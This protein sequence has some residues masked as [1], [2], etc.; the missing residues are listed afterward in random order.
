MQQ[1]EVLEK[2]TPAQTPT[3]FRVLAV[4]AL[5]AIVAIAV[6]AILMARHWPF[7][8][9][10]VVQCLQQESGNTVR[11]ANYRETYFPHPG[12]VA[13][14]VT[15]LDPESGNAPPAITIQ[16]LTIEGN[17]LGLLSQHLSTIRA[18]GLRVQVPP[19]EKRSS[20]SNFFTT[21]SN[22]SIGVLV[23]DGA[24]ISFEPSNASEQPLVFR[25]PR[26][27][28]RSIGKNHP[29]SFA[30]TVLIPLPPANVEISGQ[31]GPWKLGNAGETPISASYTLHDA[32]LS[33][34]GGIQGKVSAKG[35]L[36]GVLQRINT[37]GDTDAP[38]FMVTESHHK[39]HL[40]THYQALVNGLNGDVELQPVIANFGKTTLVAQGKIEGESKATGAGKTVAMSVYS[41]RARI[42]DLLR[43]FGSSDPPPM[44]GPVQFRAQVN[45]P[46]EDRPFLKKVRLQGDFGI[47]GAQY[48]SRETQKDV[49]VASARAMGEA[50]KV[51]DRNDK[52]H[53]DSYDPGKVLS[54]VKGHVVM[55]NAVATLTDLSFDVPGASALLNGNYDLLSKRIDFQGY[56]KLQTELSKATTGVKSVLLKIV[57]PFTK[58]KAGKGSVVNLKVTGTYHNPSFVVTPVAK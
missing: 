30:G 28:L 37:Q 14:G 6:L 38:D 43:M 57:Q 49:D 31:Y 29:T 4:V 53:N 13:E 1:V 45:I 39:V 56:V 9:A 33:V 46:P 3:R 26:L 55:H 2:P 17:Y 47:S 16:K 41:K 11:I 40:T 22:L 34:F 44:L 36:N 8:R 32:D 15:F 51:E 7:T 52:D 21:S 10:A 5:V 50:D 24:E 58:S 19:A 54:D 12:G 20:G 42:E 27:T 18:E 25:L 48:A 35:K 23:A